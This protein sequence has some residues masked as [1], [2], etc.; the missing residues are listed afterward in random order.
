MDADIGPKP[1]LYKKMKK[2]ESTGEWVLYFHFGKI[3]PYKALLPKVRALFLRNWSEKL[4][5]F[6]F[7]RRNDTFRKFEFHLAASM[8][9]TVSQHQYAL[10]RFNDL[11][12]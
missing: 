3:G 8:L 7:R 12:A 10:M 9:R 6:D 11:S 2:D 5:Y 4:Q 1:E